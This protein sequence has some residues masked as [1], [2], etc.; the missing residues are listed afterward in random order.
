M[1]LIVVSNRLPVTIGKSIEKS[2]AGLLYAMEGL[3]YSGGFQWL[4]WAGG[5]VDNFRCQ[6]ILGVKSLLV[7]IKL[8]S[9]HYASEITHGPR[10][11]N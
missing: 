11:A 6:T 9:Q 1:S 3:D 10:P 4:G 2:A 5:V 8:I 7:I